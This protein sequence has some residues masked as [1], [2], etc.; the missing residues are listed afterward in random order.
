[1]KK[2]NFDKKLILNKETISSLNTL[3]MKNV[4]GGATKFCGYTY[5]DVCNSIIALCEVQTEKC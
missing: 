4:K 2:Q 3:E 5:D 1:M